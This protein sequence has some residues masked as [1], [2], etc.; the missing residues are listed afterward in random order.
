M[1]G[2]SA[3][4]LLF[5]ASIHT[6]AKLESE[7]SPFLQGLSPLNRSSKYPDSLHVGRKN[8]D[9][10]LLLERNKINIKLKACRL[11]ELGF[12]LLAG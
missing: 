8:E 1:S 9:D 11:R 6:A 3:L 5:I 4:L 7:L 10:L 12:S 2:F